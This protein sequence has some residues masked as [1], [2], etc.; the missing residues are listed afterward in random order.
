MT[1]QFF[2]VKKIL[3]VAKKNAI[4]KDEGMQG[5]LFKKS[6]YGVIFFSLVMSFSFKVKGQTPVQLYLSQQ[7]VDE[8]K[9][10]FNK[11]IFKLF[12]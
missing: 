10:I 6:F 9:L 5:S 3:N 2:F 1:Y 11:L 4:K 12:Y 8:I 7:E